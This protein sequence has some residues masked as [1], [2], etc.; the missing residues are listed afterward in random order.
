MLVSFLF[1]SFFFYRFQLSLFVLG[2][3]L[4][5]LLAF[6]QLVEIHLFEFQF[7]PSAFLVEFLLFNNFDQYITLKECLFILNEAAY[8]KTN[9]FKFHSEFKNLKQRKNDDFINELDQEQK[10][11]KDLFSQYN[12]FYKKNNTDVLFSLIQQHHYLL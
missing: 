5:F 3:V 1:C 4:L 9:I 2:V 6:L 12:S 8:V 7:L 11:F 10:I